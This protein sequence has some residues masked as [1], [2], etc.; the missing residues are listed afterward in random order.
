MS[1]LQKLKDK[2]AEEAFGQ[3]VSNARAEG[4][5]IS[6]KQLPR[7]YSAAGRREYAISGLC[8]YCFDDITKE[9]E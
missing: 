9:D 6:C 2:L 3:C 8:E 5:C 4:L 1:Y 7:F